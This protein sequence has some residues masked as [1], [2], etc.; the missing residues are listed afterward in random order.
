MDLDKPF[1]TYDEQ[2]DLLQDRG[3]CI[4]DRE[5]ANHALSTISYYDLI[6]GY[7]NILVKSIILC[8]ILYN[9]LPVT[10]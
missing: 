5:F 2:I 3:L 6:N 10:H 8:K 4:T 1:R 9:V 7:K